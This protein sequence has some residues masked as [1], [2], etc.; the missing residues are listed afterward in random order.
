M[1]KMGIE[2]EEVRVNVKNKKTGDHF[3]L[4]RQKCHKYGKPLTWKTEDFEI[5]GDVEVVYG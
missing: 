3:L 2:Y 4:V 1:N 5:V